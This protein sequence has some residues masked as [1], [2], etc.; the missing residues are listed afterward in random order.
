VAIGPGA[1]LP[2][3]QVGL[4]QAGRRA[5]R[6]RGVRDLDLT[7]EDVVG[8]AWKV[9]SA[10]IKADGPLARLP[11]SIDARGEA[12]GGRWRI[13][14]TGDLAQNGKIY[15]L[16]LDAAGRMGRTEIKTRE[17]AKV[18]FGDGPTQARCAWPSTRGAPISTPTWAVRRPC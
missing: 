1:F 9:R 18:R 7:A 4:G 8:G 6:G 3:G 10:R 11:L 17:T 15:D 14:G 16:A 2:Q 5:W 12:P 13:G